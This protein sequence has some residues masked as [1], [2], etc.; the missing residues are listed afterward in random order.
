MTPRE[1]FVEA[2]RPI[3][4]QH[5]E[6]CHCLGV[7]PYKCLVELAIEGFA[8]M[9]CQAEGYLGHSVPGEC[10]C[11]ASLLR[12]CGLTNGEKPSET[13]ADHPEEFIND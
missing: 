1:R 5:A 12:D 4:E 8:D 2:M 7:A 3:Y 13:Y 10:I 9:E 6:I 11:R